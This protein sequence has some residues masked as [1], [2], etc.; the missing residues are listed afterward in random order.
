[1]QSLYRPFRRKR[2]VIDLETLLTG[3]LEAEKIVAAT[4][5][6]VLLS[7]PAD[8]RSWLWN[9]S[10]IPQTFVKG[11]VPMLIAQALAEYGA[12]AVVIEALDQTWIAAEDYVRGVDGTTWAAVM[13]AAFLV[14]YVLGHRR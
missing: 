7:R 9:C 6:P 12:L 4:S 11:D 14:W 1:M 8:H 13:F 10:E 5:N 2:Q 3:W